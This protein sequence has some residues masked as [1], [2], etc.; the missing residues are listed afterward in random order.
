MGIGVAESVGIDCKLQ[1]QGTHCALDSSAQ[2]LL[3]GLID[4]S[5]LPT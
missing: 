1:L 5:I 4:I 2:T 3:T